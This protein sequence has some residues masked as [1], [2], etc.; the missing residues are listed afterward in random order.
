MRIVVVEDAAPI[1]EG[2]GKIL[3][4]LGS[5]YE[6]AGTAENGS[7]GLEMIEELK[8]DLVI[9]DIKMPDMDGLTM[10]KKLRERKNKCKAIVLTAY[11]DFD[12]AKQ[13]I[14]LGIE[15]YLLKPIKIPE[16]KRALKLALDTLAIEKSQDHLYHLDSIMYSSLMG[17][18]DAY[19]GLDE[20]ACERYGL[21][22]NGPM[23]LFLVWLGDAYESYK[24]VAVT[25]LETAEGNS[26]NFNGQ[27]LNW[28]ENRTVV[29]VI[30]NKKPDYDLELYFQQS[31]VPMMVSN[32][33]HQAAF[34]WGISEGLSGLKEGAR[35][36]WNELGWNL[37]FPEGTLVTH[38][39]IEDSRLTPFKYPLELE[40]KIRQAIAHGDRQ[41][42][43]QCLELFHNAC[44]EE[45][46][47]LQEIQDGCLLLGF[48]MVK[49]AREY[50]NSLEGISTQE[51]LQKIT[52]C[53]TWDSLYCISEKFFE[54]ILSGRPQMEGQETSV[55]VQK[56]LSLIQ[57]Y[58][59]Q[60]ITLE[61]IARKLYV[62]DEYLS[63][64]FKKETGRTFTE[65]IRSFRI[66]KIRKLLLESD[67]KLNQIA[68]MTGFS[69]PKYMSKV[70]RE[71]VGISP[72][73]YR[74]M[75]I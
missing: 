33:K 49:S 63:S 36:I 57:E 46:H 60:G 17:R 58:Y 47:S 3:K 2:L 66:E 34:G 55:L 40:Q 39:K 12:Y 19:D 4:K 6:L 5:E 68:A 51:I 62:S 70:F 71:E 45:L 64:L 75:N 59:N 73:E 1:R 21:D 53:F 37:I 44:V 10:L 31:V 20:V 13:A 25:L 69:D 56:A 24:D 16:L 29:L 18:L 26:Q 67:L 65:T 38:K 74:K 15:N 72:A 30:Y 22:C 11:S 7:K 52:G 50:G 28:E 42:F 35:Q 54:H 8:P 9:M 27:L 14:E 43:S 41:G 61:E 32:L 23:Y 48:A